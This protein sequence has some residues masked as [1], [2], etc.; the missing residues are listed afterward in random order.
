MATLHI[1]VLGA[2]ALTDEEATLI[3]PDGSVVPLNLAERRPLSQLDTG[4]SSVSVG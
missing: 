1:R 3:R 4:D 2:Q